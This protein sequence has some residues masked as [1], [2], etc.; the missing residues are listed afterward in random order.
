[1]IKLYLFVCLFV[2]LRW[3]CDF[4]LVVWLVGSKWFSFFFD[5]L[6]KTSD[7]RSSSQQA[8]AK[9]E[10]RCRVV[11]VAVVTLATL[12]S[13]ASA[14]RWTGWSAHA[15][16]DS[17]INQ[18]NIWKFG[19]LGNLWRF[20]NLRSVVA[21]SVAHRDAVVVLA[22]ACDTVGCLFATAA[23]VAVQCQA[24]LREKG[25]G[26]QGAQNYAADFVHFC[27]FLVECCQLIN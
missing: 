11:V 21:S 12:G 18:S 24:L 10:G 7:S 8:K 26:Q 5:C 25:Q 16:V 15:R 3:M 19:K 4:C 23:F 22:L 6:E 2:F 27:L 14:R 20:R 17:E 1:M 9:S 13:E